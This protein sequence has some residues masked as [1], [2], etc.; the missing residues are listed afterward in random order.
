MWKTLHPNIRVRIVTSFLS[1]LVGGAVFPLL[2]IY[3]TEHLGA[4][5]AGL[6]LGLL[7]AVQ[8][9][10]GLYGGLLAD[11]WGRRR[12]LLLGEVLKALAFA[13]LLAANWQQPFPYLTF[14]A[15]ALVNLA[16]GLVGPASEAMLVDVSTPES[17]SFMYSVNYWAINASLLIGTLLGGWLYRDHFPLLLELLL[18]M[19]L[20]TLWLSWTRLSETRAGQS[21]HEVGAQLGLG[22]LLRNYAAV[23]RDPA[24]L[25]F[26]AGG[27]A[28]LTIEFGRS[29]WAAVHLAQN[30]APLLLGGQLIDGVRAMSLLTAV[31]TGL[32]VLLTAPVSA[33]VTRQPQVPVMYAGFL[34]FG[35]GFAVLAFSVSLP[36]LLLASVVLTLGELLYV[37]TRQSRL[38]DLI[39]AEGRGAYLAING[40][41][42]TVAKWAASLGVPLGAII[43]GPGMAALTLGLGVLGMWLTSLALRRRSVQDQLQPASS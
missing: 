31:N 15:V 21:T 16:G 5:R 34:L 29:N 18:G 40:Q 3:F 4:G 43:G 17:R 30:F 28:V 32:I 20:L 27:V 41:L 33:W 7:V 10:A 26:T 35:A 2:A 6:L 37:P 11:L 13:A 19:S 9:A 23:A 8:F 25:L 12:T 22:S 24:F 39:P 1:R 38:A 14:A 42:F 36:A